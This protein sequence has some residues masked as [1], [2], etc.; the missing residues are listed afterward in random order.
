MRPDSIRAGSCGSDD[1][2]ERHDGMMRGKSEKMESMTSVL[3]AVSSHWIS[4]TL[5]YIC[6]EHT[7]SSSYAY[8]VKDYV[9]K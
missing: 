1:G 6:I 8:R 7:H 2:V 9:H 4:A 5:E 3:T